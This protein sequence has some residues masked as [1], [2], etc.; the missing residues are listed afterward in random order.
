MVQFTFGFAGR[1]KNDVLWVAPG[2]HG[3]NDFVETG[4]FQPQSSL[5]NRFEGGG[6]GIG[7]DRKTMQKIGWKRSDDVGQK[8]VQGLKIVEMCPGSGGSG[9]GGFWK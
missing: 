5:M 9:V 4:T 1:I 2:V 8:C 3:M 7:F 6:Q